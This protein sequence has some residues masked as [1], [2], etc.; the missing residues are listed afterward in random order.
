[1]DQYMVLE[2]R[3]HARRMAMGWKRLGYSSP[4]LKLKPKGI[5]TLCH[6][7]EVKMYERTE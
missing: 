2:K 4:K 5:R 3:P 1:M 7:E 6:S